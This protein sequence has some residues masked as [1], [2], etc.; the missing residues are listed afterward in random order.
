MRISTSLQLGSI[1]YH[2]LADSLCRITFS[3]NVQYSKGIW[4]CSGYYKTCHNPTLADP[5]CRITF[6]PNVQYSKG[7]WHCSGYYKTC[8]NPTHQRGLAQHALRAKMTKIGRARTKNAAK[9]GSG[10]GQSAARYGKTSR[11]QTDRQTHTHVPTD[12]PSFYIYIGI[13]VIPLFI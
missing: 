2:L 10:K 9:F 11:G 12:R 5:L 4:H 7:I 3:P 1:Y 6:S 13:K 8:H